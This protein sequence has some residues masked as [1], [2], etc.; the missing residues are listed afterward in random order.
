M[1]LFPITPPQGFPGTKPPA[2]QLNPV[3]PALARGVAGAM[4]PAPA[5]A[6]QPGN[7]SPLGQP[8]T[9]ENWQQQTAP[10]FMG[11]TNAQGAYNQ[12]SP[13]LAGMAQGQG[14]QFSADAARGFNAA[15]DPGL[16]R[17]YQNAWQQGSADIDK[18][19]AA[20]GMGNSGAAMEAAAKLRG[21]LGAEQANREA[22]YGLRRAQIGG[23]L[24]GQASS[25]ALGAGGQRLGAAAQL[26]GLAQG[27]DAGNLGRMVAG[28]NFARQGQEA[29]EGRERGAFDDM[30][31]YGN[32]VSG[33]M[34]PGYEN[35]FSS[36][37]MLFGQPIEAALAAMGVKIQGEEAR[38][39]GM[40]NAAGLGLGIAQLAK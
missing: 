27:A 8:G 33:V 15:T 11:P 19:F 5:S 28:G 23:Q 32:A 36:D 30:L 14:P 12:T 4:Q 10:W 9:F 31:G 2:N 40:R 21:N 13:L 37:A 20:K 17:F 35:L 16:G 39:A 26:G 3:N 6:G 7:T 24:A 25:E 22:D 38:R 1:P 18:Q 34:A 29:L